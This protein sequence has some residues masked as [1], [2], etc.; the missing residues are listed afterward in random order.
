MANIK[1]STVAFFG[2]TGG[3]VLSCLIL[4]LNAGRHCTALVRNPSKLQDMLQQHGVSDSII[5]QNLTL[6]EGNVTDVAAVQQALLGPDNQPVD[7]VI[8]GIGGRMNFSNPIWPTLDDPTV[9]QTAMRTILTAARNLSQ[10]PQLVV[11]STTGISKKRDLPVAMMP[12]YH[13]MLKVPHEDKRQMEALIHQEM[14]RPLGER[15]ISDFIIVRPSFLTDGDGDG[16]AKIKEGTEEQ[17]AVGYV[18]SRSDVGRWLF[19]RVVRLGKL[20]RE[21]SLYLGKAITITT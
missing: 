2:A 21:Q 1:L 11:L 3:C 7:F 20:S 6:I 18:I 4:T 9:C 13:W 17:P 16:M 12:M 14:E 5:K 8:S 10:A 19:E 15:A